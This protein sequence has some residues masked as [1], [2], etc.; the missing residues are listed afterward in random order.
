MAQ[1]GSFND[2]SG[3]TEEKLTYEVIGE[4][5]GPVSPEEKGIWNEKL[6]NKSFQY[7]INDMQE[8][9]EAVCM[10]TRD[11]IPANI[12]PQ[13][14]ESE[15]SMQGAETG[16]VNASAFGNGTQALPS[17]ERTTPF[18]SESFSI[19]PL[20]HALVD[21]ETNASGGRVVCHPFIKDF[22]A[23]GETAVVQ[24]DNMVEQKATSPLK[25]ELTECSGVNVDA[26]LHDPNMSVT[27]K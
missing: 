18:T 16:E 3:E 14:N 11:E 22:A 24:E 12:L 9:S 27:I 8:K 10:D 17:E 20:D 26:E 13:D 19:S 23:S 4:V 2:V 1:L 15:T 5:A 6:P 21:G 25:A 7:S